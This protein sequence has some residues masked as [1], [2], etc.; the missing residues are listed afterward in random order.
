MLFASGD[1]L[2]GLSKW[3][4]MALAV[5]ELRSARSA[6]T[7]EDL[8]DLETD[9]LAGFVLARA[10]AGM[11]DATVRHDLMYLEQV[12]TWLGRPLWTM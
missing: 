9:L 10:S 5:A 3:G 1:G 2:S 12:R 8:E 11:A 4:L 6:E 7:P